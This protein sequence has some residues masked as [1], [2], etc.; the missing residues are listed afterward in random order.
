MRRGA[1]LT[2]ILNIVDGYVNESVSVKRA[3]EQKK[4]RAWTLEL[5]KLW[6]LFCKH[7]DFSGW[8][9]ES[10]ASVDFMTSP[11]ESSMFCATS[12]SF[13][14][15]FVCYTGNYHS[16]LNLLKFYSWKICLRYKAMDSLPPGHLSPRNPRVELVLGGS[17]SD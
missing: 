4:A 7:H 8:K 14:F 6:S 1:A 3:M 15:F 16:D 5:G 12:S 9:S 11:I 13:S 17:D 2:A 10:R